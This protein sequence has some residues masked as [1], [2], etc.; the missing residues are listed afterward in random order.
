MPE[1]DMSA[2]GRARA[3]LVKVE[4]R[5][6]HLMA[7]LRTAQET[8]TQ[9]LRT[10]ASAEQIALADSALQRLLQ[11]QTS[12]RT[13]K[14]NALKGVLRQRDALVTLFTPDQLVDTLS[15]AHP[16]VMLPV[17]LET[18]FFNNAQELRVRI[19]PDQIH[20]DQH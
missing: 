6:Q 2:I 4:A 13:T 7:D 19:Y 14:R 18:R 10:A 11:Q 16:V 5:E 17:R 20:L 8:H 15:G 1:I 12:L 3:T 9:L